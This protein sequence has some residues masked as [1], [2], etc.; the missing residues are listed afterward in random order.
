MHDS[1]MSSDEDDVL[2]VTAIDSPPENR[3]SDT[4]TFSFSF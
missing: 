2:Y 3:R 4:Y 1:D